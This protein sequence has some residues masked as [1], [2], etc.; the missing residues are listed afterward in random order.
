MIDFSQ[1]TATSQVYNNYVSLRDEQVAAGNIKN[2]YYASECV[3]EEKGAKRIYDLAPGITM[4]ILDQKFYYETSTDENDHSVC[5]MF[6]Q[7]NNHYLFT[8]DL[9]EKGEASLV[10]LNN[11]PEVELFKGGHHGSYTANT[12]TLLNV[13]KP[14]TICI[15]CCAGT[16][17]YTTTSDNTFPAQAAIN[18]MGKWTDKIYVTTLMI[19]YS[20]GNY[21]SMNGNINFRCE[22]DEA[23][24]VT[25]SNNST[26][27]KETEWFSANRTWPSA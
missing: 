3:K 9:E 12:D 16:T 26:I 5:T 4:E 10:A 7:G 13:I 1:T 25:G 15:C 20:A 23:Y 22:K 17:E 2:H 19:D 24:V 21:T 11:L 8:G 27:L 18:R 14:K 6:T